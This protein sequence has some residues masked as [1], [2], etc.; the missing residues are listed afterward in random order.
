MKVNIMNKVVDV[1]ISNMKY[2][3]ED[4][5]LL[6]AKVY[7][8][9]MTMN[10]ELLSLLASHTEIKNT[11]FKKIGDILIFDKQEFAWL[12]DSKEFLPDSYTSYANKIGLSSNRK[13]ISAKNDVVL[14]F[15][16]KDCYLEG[17]QDKEDQKRDEIFY[18][19]LIAHDEITNML[20]PKVFTKAKKYVTKAAKD[21]SGESVKG[22]TEVVVENDITLDEDDNLIIK[23]NN[24]IALSSLLKRFE[25]KVKLIYIDPPY[26][27]GGDANIF[28]YNNTF[29][30][31]TWLTFMKNRL[32]LSKEF[33]KPDGF[34][35]IAI[36]HFELFYLGVLTDEVFGRENRVGIITVV[37]KPE[38]RNQEKFI[39]SSN[40]FMLIYAK[41]KSK[42]NFNEVIFDQEKIKDFKYK[43]NY[44]YYKLMDYIRFGGGDHNLRKNKPHFYYPIYVDSSTLEVSLEYK[45]DS[46][47][48][49]P[50]RDDG[51]ERTWKTKKET[52]AEKLKDN[53]IIATKNV[54][55]KITVCEKYYK[56]ENGQ[57]IKSH[58]ID[59]RYNAIHSGTRLLEKLL[60]RKDFSYPK[61]LY[62]VKDTIAIMTSKDDIIMDFFAGSGTTGHATLLLNKEDEGERKFI[63]IEQLEEHIKICCERINKVLE[64]EDLDSSYVYFELKESGQALI[65]KINQSSEKDIDE[66]KE[67]IYSDERIIPYITTKELEESDS[68]FNCLS[69][70]DKKKVLIEL[71][72]K[73]KLYV[74]LSDIE[75]IDENISIT[76]KHFTNSFYR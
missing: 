19:E 58:W 36:D 30:H 37:H 33:L 11:F 23:G 8:D 51:Q 68:S 45:P 64:Q 75:D 18:H 4:G 76:D 67:I 26:N 65:N 54:D 31:S 60:G 52:F 25:G 50:I 72:N 48:V 9:V 29:N 53:R 15:P 2:V 14:D 47:A 34:I 41:D 35:A 57:L 40:E 5:T 3:A 32:E 10:S 20:E 55:G 38:G 28:T 71:I 42:A 66:I 7:S 27:T 16:Y 22:S 46:V 13:Y 44:D 74:N 17:G 56:S 39:S 73:N 21:L 61:S 12:L 43:D 63:L 1:L 70:E 69:L 49:Y 62:L 6:K 24:L 59:K